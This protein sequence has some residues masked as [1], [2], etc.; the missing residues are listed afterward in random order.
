MKTIAR[1]FFPPRPADAPAEPDYSQPGV[2]VTSPRA[3]GWSPTTP[4]TSASRTSF[5]TTTLCGGRSSRR[6]GLRFL[7]AT[8]SG[9]W[10][11]RSSPALPRTVHRMGAPV[12]REAGP[13]WT[14]GGIAAQAGVGDHA[15][16]MNA[17]ADDGFVLFAGPL[18][19]TEADRVRALVVVDAESEMEIHDRL[20]ADPWV[21]SDHLRTVTV[22]V[23]NP[24][25]GLERVSNS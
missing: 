13:A 19:G 15:A 9:S 23:W 12:I 1:P 18:T 5:L 14:D 4:S 3:P 6:P 11:M 10:G 20:A 25:V 8:V 2:L 7:R 16:F 24:L 17:L 22:E 21:H